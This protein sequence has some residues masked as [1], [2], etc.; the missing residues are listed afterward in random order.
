MRPQGLQLSPLLTEDAQDGGI[1]GSQEVYGGDEE[2][3]DE[4]T[5]SQP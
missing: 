1:S 5:W 3:R 2:S 4:N